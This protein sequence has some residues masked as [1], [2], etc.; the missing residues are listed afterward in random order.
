[1]GTGADDAPHAAE[2]CAT[3]GSNEAAAAVMGWGMK[4]VQITDPVVIDLLCE[5]QREAVR[6]WNEREARLGQPGI[7][8]SSELPW[9]GEYRFDME[10]DRVAM[11]ELGLEPCVSVHIHMKAPWSHYCDGLFNHDSFHRKPITDHSQIKKVLL[12]GP[13]EAP[14]LIEMLNDWLLAG[15]IYLRP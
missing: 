5:L 7:V 3:A 1:V 10:S 11:F 9:G 6:Q 13:V 14:T 8:Q 12:R 2:P 4:R 15:E